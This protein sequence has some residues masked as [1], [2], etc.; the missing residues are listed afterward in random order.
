MAVD[1]VVQ[2]GSTRAINSLV[3]NFHSSLAVGE[4]HLPKRISLALMGKITAR[5]LAMHSWYLMGV[6]SVLSATDGSLCNPYP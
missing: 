4:Y 3:L 6:F 5:L 1:E 2:H